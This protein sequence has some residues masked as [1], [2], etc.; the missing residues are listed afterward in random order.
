MNRLLSDYDNLK[1]VSYKGASYKLPPH[2][3]VH[4]HSVAFN[5]L[6]PDGSV[7]GQIKPYEGGLDLSVVGRKMPLTNTLDWAQVAV[8]MEAFHPGVLGDD[9]WF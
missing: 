5:L 9:L 1:S 8:L 6:G 2:R 3:W 7:V 4:L